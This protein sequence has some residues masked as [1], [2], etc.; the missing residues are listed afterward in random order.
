MPSLRR[1]KIIYLL[2][3]APSVFPWAVMSLIGLTVGVGLLGFAG[4]FGLR[5]IF[6]LPIQE[7]KQRWTYNTL[8]L[9]GMIP[10]AIYVPFIAFNM[11]NDW[12][13]WLLFFS[14]L[15]LLLVATCLIYEIN[16]AEKSD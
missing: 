12:T 6:L 15:I 3:V 14:G 8:L 1:R 9:L 13:N 2:L 10:M 7:R 11:M 16:Y 4:I 5:S